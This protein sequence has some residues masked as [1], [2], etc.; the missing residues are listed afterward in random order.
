METN[1]ITLLIESRRG[2]PCNRRFSGTKFKTQ[3]KFEL[4]P[5]IDKSLIRNLI[6]V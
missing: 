5:E 3:T 4:A 2:F 1:R 6:L